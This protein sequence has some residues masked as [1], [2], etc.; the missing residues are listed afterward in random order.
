MKYLFQIV[1][2]LSLFLSCKSNSEKKSDAQVQ[3]RQD[4]IQQENKSNLD[5]VQSLLNFDSTLFNL[6]LEHKLDLKKNNIYSATVLF[7]WNEIRGK[8]DSSLVIPD[9]FED[10][11]ILNKSQ[12]FFDVLNP[13]EY[14]V[15]IKLEDGIS[16]TSSFEISLN[17]KHALKSYSDFNFNKDKV[18]GFGC[19]GSQSEVSYQIRVLF[20]ENDDHFIVQLNPSNEEH[21]ILLFMTPNKFETMSDYLEEMNKK[22]LIGQE[23][24]KDKNKNWRVLFNDEDLVQIPKFNFNISTVYSSLIGNTFSSKFNSKHII[25]NVEQR[26]GFNLDEKGAYVESTAEFATDSVI[27]EIPTPKSLVFNKPF[28]MLAKRKSSLNPYFCMWVANT[29]L[30]LNK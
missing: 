13:N 9:N 6:T 18:L 24:W 16:A 27:A 8:L 15:E 7:A 4:S 5:S 17:F 11:T 19:L 29:E 26:I 30:M 23:H 3:F 2:V 28:L 12:S 10:L 1:I 25:L 22:I 21:H 14:K 20:Y